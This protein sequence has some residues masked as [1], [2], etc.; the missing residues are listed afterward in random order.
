MSCD[1]VWD[2]TKGKGVVDFVLLHH[3]M[4]ALIVTGAR[5]TLGELD[6]LFVVVS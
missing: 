5:S 3:H 6:V 4:G 1:A 2:V